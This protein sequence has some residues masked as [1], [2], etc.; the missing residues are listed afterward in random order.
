[1]RWLDL[2]AYG[3]ELKIN[4]DALGK[5]ALYVLNNGDAI[6]FALE[7]AGFHRRQTGLWFRLFD[8]DEIGPILHSLV[9]DL[10]AVRVIP[11]SPGEIGFRQVPSSVPAAVGVPDAEPEHTSHSTADEH[12]RLLSSDVVDCPRPEDPWDPR[13]LA[14]PAPS[15]EARG[16]IPIAEAAAAQETVAQREEDTTRT[17]RGF[18]WKIPVLGLIGRENPSEPALPR[19]EPTFENMPPQP[20]EAE[21]IVSTMAQEAKEMTGRDDLPD[22]CHLLAK[23]RDPSD[24]A[25][26]RKLTG[27][28]VVAEAGPNGATEIQLI[29]LIDAGDCG[30][31]SEGDVLVVGDPGFGF[32]AA[33]L[34]EPLEAGRAA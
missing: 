28:R 13:G 25:M 31:G 32:G 26:L 14:E 1:M 5:P 19:H 16:V 6:D 4:T 8:F 29:G 18:R 20:F 15:D 23:L 9:T 30:L 2:S 24:A 11:M 34:P 3:T 22:H 10:P 12:A 21:W 33:V 7:R 27:E 17:R